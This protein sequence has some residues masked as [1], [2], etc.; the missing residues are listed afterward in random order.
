VGDAVAAVCCHNESELTLKCHVSGRYLS[1]LTARQMFLLS[2]IVRN[3]CPSL[4]G[5]LK[6]LAIFGDRK[7]SIVFEVVY[8]GTWI[9][10]YDASLDR[11]SAFVWGNHL[12]FVVASSTTM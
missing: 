11:I 1:L 4:V 2:I 12:V 3:C 5:Q 9:D 8:H 10:T 6:K 7:A